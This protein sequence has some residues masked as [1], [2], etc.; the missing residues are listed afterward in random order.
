MTILAGV[1]SL[2]YAHLGEDA[3]WYDVSG[4]LH[5]GDEWWNRIVAEITARDTFL[6]LFSPDA[7]ASDWVPR[8]MG[9]AYWQ[10]VK[11]GKRL[12]PLMHR[13]CEVPADWQLIQALPFTDDLPYEMR[14]TSLLHEM[15]YD[16]A[17]TPQTLGSAPVAETVSK[18]AETPRSR[19]AARLTQE[20]HTAFGRENWRQVLLRARTLQ[21]EASEA[22]T[23]QLWREQGLAALEL[24]D[25]TNALAALNNALKSDPYDLPTIRAKVQA[26]IQL[27]QFDE[28][29][30]L[31]ERAQSFIPIDD[32]EPQMA[33]LVDLITLLEQWEQWGKMIVACDQ[34][35]ALNP[36]RALSWA[37]KG[38]A[39]NELKRY[40]EAIASCDQ[41]IAVDATLAVAW[42]RKG[43]ALNYLARYEEALDAYNQ[44]IAL[45]PNSAVTWNNKGSALSNLKRYDE[46][47][48]AYDQSIS[49]D[50]Y[51][52]VVWN[53]KADALRMLGRIEEANEAIHRGR[54]L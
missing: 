49:L 36:H 43:Y 8:E 47:L 2:I 6:V 24:K 42:N 20:I 21:E 52:A 18:T 31:L 16:G 30:R 14:L 3:V 39:L 12:M 33:L 26:L 41:A 44:S 19:L 1:W 13:T 37:S 4:G 46:A 10:H 9:I 29:S 48:A 40:R 22:M 38:R 5:G 28:A 25:G 11:L 32:V 35:I 53:N 34:A 23:A 17:I 54:A 50:P 45:D 7:L 27:K 15:G 51:V